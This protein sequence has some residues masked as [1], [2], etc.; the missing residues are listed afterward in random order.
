MAIFTYGSFIY[1]YE[2]VREGRK[3]LSL[4]VK[5]DLGIVVKCPTEASNERIE[6]FLK[7]KWFWLQKQLQ[8]FKKFQRKSVQKEYVSGESFLYLGRQYMLLVKSGDENNV[9]LSHGKINLTTALLATDKSYNKLLLERWYRKRTR[10]VFSERLEEMLKLFDYTKLPKLG[11]RDMPKR[12]GSFV[13]NNT[14]FLNPRLIGAPKE[15]ID[16]VIIHELCHIKHRDH[17]NK[18]YQLLEAKCPDWEKRKEKLE[19]YLG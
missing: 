16:Y 5:P 15:C 8:Y 6:L 13:G 19:T 10:A 14:I 9:S 17:N 18:F 2:L 4:T 12:W 1:K 11:I 7:R 3:T